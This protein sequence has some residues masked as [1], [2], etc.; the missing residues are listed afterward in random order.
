MY[1]FVALFS[2]LISLSFAPAHS[3]NQSYT[4]ND[5]QQAITLESADTSFFDVNDDNQAV[6]PETIAVQVNR[7]IIGKSFVCIPASQ[8][9]AVFNQ[10]IR[11]PPQFS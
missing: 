11:A 10:S 4:P 2:L 6:L 7:L 8:S 1:K 3:A 5:F 9:K